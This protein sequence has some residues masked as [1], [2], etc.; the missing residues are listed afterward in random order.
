MDTRST[1][2]IVASLV[3]NAQAM[4]A[5]EVELVG[6][7]VRRLIARRIA[8]F[9]VLLV[10]ALTGAA[11]LLLGAVTAALALESSF[12]EPWM[13]WGVVTLVVAVVTLVLLAFAGRRLS[14]SWSLTTSRR[15]AASTG[16]WLRE[17]GAEL[18]G[19][20]TDGTDGAPGP[21]DGGADAAR[22]GSR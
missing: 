15:A 21:R 7:E 3:V 19:T 9:A 13:A 22:G 18:T 5:K 6:L 16:A 12:D 1:G 17:L 10:A 14:A 4:I 11:V 2:E 8:A 20:G